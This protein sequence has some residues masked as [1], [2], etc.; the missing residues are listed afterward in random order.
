MTKRALSLISVLATLFISQAA[1]AQLRWV[2]HKF[3][4]EE[5]AVP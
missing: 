2:A 4:S 5:K 1:L 3:C